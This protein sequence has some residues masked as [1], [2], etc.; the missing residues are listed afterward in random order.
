MTP[1][2]DLPQDHRVLDSVNGALL[3]G[4]V[5][6][7]LGLDRLV[8]DQDNLIHCVREGVFAPCEKCLA[9]LVSSI[10]S[11]LMDA[12]WSKLEVKSVY[13]PSSQCITIANVMLAPVT[14]A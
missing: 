3:A 5:P 7:A 13:F 11:R 4:V 14:Q 6:E 8:S 9:L 1:F 2:H 10:G 12:S